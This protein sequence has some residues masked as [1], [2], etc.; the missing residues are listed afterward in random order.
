MIV[1]TV[2]RSCDLSTSDLTKSLV[3]GDE[4]IFTF[5]R[6]EELQ[7]NATFAGTGI[8]CILWVSHDVSSSTPLKLPKETRRESS[9]VDIPHRVGSPV[10]RCECRV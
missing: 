3:L 5:L 10:L 9:S 4:S 7:R 2:P 6:R 1:R 8:K